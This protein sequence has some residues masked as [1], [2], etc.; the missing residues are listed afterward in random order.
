MHDTQ[1]E[2]GEKEAVLRKEELWPIGLLRDVLLP[3]LGLLLG[4]RGLPRY[5]AGEEVVLHA[6]QGSRH[7]FSPHHVVINVR[8]NR[9]IKGL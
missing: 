5:L 4:V 1:P 9:P 3:L 7:D 2:Q 8:E 6:R